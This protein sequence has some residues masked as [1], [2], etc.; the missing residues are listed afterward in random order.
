MDLT[1]CT[2]GWKN[3]DRPDARSVPIFLQDLTYCKAIALFS[4][5]T[6]HTY[7]SILETYTV[8]LY[9]KKRFISHLVG[10]N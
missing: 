3:G 4:A 1:K 10:A 2:D 5:S 6:P 9:S 7:D 8:V